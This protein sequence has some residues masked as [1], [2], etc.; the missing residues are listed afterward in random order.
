MN[1]EALRQGLPDPAFFVSAPFKST[2]ADP[3]EL[4][5]EILLGVYIS[6][7]GSAVNRRVRK[8]KSWLW[9][10]R[11]GFEQAGYLEALIPS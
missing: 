10:I 9:A 6:I 2:K 11:R 5:A 7:G 8:A 3:T 1:T 4:K